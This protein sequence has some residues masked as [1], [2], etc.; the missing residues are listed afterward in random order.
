MSPYPDIPQ[1]SIKA[2]YKEV[3]AALYG[4]FWLITDVKGPRSLRIKMGTLES[5]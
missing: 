5:L 4:K 1:A 2:W 3:S